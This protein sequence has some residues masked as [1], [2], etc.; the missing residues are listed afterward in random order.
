MEWSQERLRALIIP[1]GT[2]PEAAWAK[3]QCYRNMSGSE[4]LRIASQLTDELRARI[5]E[6]IRANH[7]DY[8]QERVRLAEFRIWL[9]VEL[10][11]KAFPD[12]KIPDCGA[13]CLSLKPTDP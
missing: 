13:C 12:A 10:F 11:E 5:A 1:P 3:V 6:G 7:P 2:S 8:S 4:K 9:G